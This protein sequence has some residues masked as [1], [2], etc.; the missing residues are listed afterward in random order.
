MAS[1]GWGQTYYL[2]SGGDKKWDFADIANWSNNFAAGIDAANWGSVAINA[3]GTAGDGVKISTSTAAFS[4][5]T[6]GGVQKGTGNVYLL[7]TSTANSCA[8]DLY[9]NF[10]G[11]KAGTISFDVATVF[12]STGNRD[13]QL[14]LFY[15]LNGTTFTEITGTGLPYTAR[16]NV[17]G[18]ASVTVTLPSAL[19]NNASVRLR[20]Y[21]NSTATGGTTPTGSQPKISIDNVNILMAS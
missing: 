18:S 14:K 4:T 6:S 2:M 12:N 8:I 13:S 16:N 1:T 10:S 9:L 11:R 7:S 17:A 20:F 19:D 5:S 3:S 15:T 21:E